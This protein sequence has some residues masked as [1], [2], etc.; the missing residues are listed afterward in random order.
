[1]LGWIFDGSDW[2]MRADIVV[3][4]VLCIA[5]WIALKKDL[6]ART[7]RSTKEM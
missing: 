4:F 2:A 5:Y 6:T 1:M 7:E 3:I